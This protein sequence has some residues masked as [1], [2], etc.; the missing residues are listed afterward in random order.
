MNKHDIEEQVIDILKN[1]DFGGYVCISDWQYVCSGCLITC[2][3]YDEECECVRFYCGD[4]VN[5][6]YAEEVFPI[7]EMKFAIYTDIV[8]AYS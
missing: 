5:D 2:V 7:D 4:M 6:K 3:E 1:E 8:D